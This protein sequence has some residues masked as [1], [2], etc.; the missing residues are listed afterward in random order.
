LR[1]ACKIDGRL[2]EWV[3]SFGQ[4]N[5]FRYLRGG[6]G[7]HHRLRV[8]ESDVLGGEYAEAARD[9]E[10]ISA[11]LN[12]TREPVERRVGV[13][14]SQRLD[15]RGGKVVVLLAALVVCVARAPQ[16]LCDS[17]L[18]DSADAFLVRLRSLDRGFERGE[19]DARVA[20]RRVRDA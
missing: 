3:E 2:R 11:A 20:A 19:R 12:Q 9:E 15:E 18:R 17:L 16:S 8:C 1:R 10:R 14:I 4:P 7:L 6:G 13:G 5:E